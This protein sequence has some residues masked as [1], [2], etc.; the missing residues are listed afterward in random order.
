MLDLWDYS[1]GT[2]LTCSKERE[3]VRKQHVRESIDWY[4]FFCW[5]WFTWAHYIHKPP[6]SILLKTRREKISQGWCKWQWTELNTEKTEVQNWLFSAANIL[7]ICP[8]TRIYMCCFHSLYQHMLHVWSRIQHKHT[9]NAA[10]RWLRYVLS[11]TF[12][13]Q[14]FVNGFSQRRYFTDIR[15]WSAWTQLLL[16]LL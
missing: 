4:Q 13:L 14:H 7:F 1:S 3:R 8:S 2:R 12:N 9:D 10:S 15:R 16:S 6:G 11:S 5:S